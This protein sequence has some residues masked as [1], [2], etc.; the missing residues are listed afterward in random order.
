MKTMDR[1]FATEIEFFLFV[2]CVGS[3]NAQMF[4]LLLQQNFSVCKPSFF[5][6]DSNVIPVYALHMYFNV[7]SLFDGS[8]YYG[9]L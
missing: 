3:S 8:F 5:M 1:Y 6:R 4:S 7:F 9:F 2:K